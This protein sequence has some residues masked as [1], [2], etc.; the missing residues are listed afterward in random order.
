MIARKNKL[1]RIT[2]AFE[3]K[4][5]E[6][7]EA[8]NIVDGPELRQ[9]QLDNFDATYELYS[10]KK[11]V[12]LSLNKSIQTQ[13]AIDRFVSASVAKRGVT[14]IYYGGG[15]GKLAFRG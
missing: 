8:R 1:E 10:K 7:R 15:W 6:E 4:L 5:R 14:E 3:T 9:F 2:G 13:T 12:R 11:V